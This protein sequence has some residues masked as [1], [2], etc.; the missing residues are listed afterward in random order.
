MDKRIGYMATL[1]DVSARPSATVRRGSYYLMQ[2]RK[3]WLVQGIIREG[4]L[5]FLSAKEGTGKSFIALELASCIAEGREFF[6]NAVSHVEAVYVAA[7]RGDSQRERI[8]A[9]RDGKGVNPDC[10]N[11]IDDQFNLAERADTDALIRSLAG[12]ETAPKLLVLD[13]LRASF[14]GDENSS[15][16]AQA[17][18]NN[19]NRIRKQFD[20]TVLV[21]HHVNAFGKSRGSSAFIGA[22]DTELYMYASTARNAGGRVYLTVRKQNN[23]RK[24]TRYNLVPQE[25]DYGDGYSS[26][27]FNLHSVEG[28]D[29]SPAEEEEEAT[30]LRTAILEVLAS[31]DDSWSLSAMQAGI[32]AIT[33]KLTNKETLKAELRTL[34]DEGLLSFTETG[35]RFRIERVQD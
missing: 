25:F 28:I 33:G 29:L 19:I 10:I 24:Y 35:G 9:L 14:M 32:Q 15:A 8:E 16:V 6:G 26:I 31:G 12:M 30:T 21:L 7:E 11:F 13:T 27:V 2:P 22:A 4:T 18:M 5:V 1:I 20:C 23:G 3:P 34:A 17:V